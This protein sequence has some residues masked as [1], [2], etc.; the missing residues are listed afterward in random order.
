MLGAG[1]HSGLHCKISGKWLREMSLG[2]DAELKVSQMRLISDF[3]DYEKYLRRI[4][5]KFI[6]CPVFLKNL[7]E[8]HYFIHTRC[9]GREVLDLE[10]KDNKYSSCEK[11]E[12]PE[13]N[14]AYC[15]TAHLS[16]K[17]SNLDT[18]HSK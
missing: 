15:D 7:M 6:T 4:A 17:I 8:L 3:G 1:N 13:R 12:K 9:C 16:I 11:L 2:D 10:E 18:C 14:Q 5:S